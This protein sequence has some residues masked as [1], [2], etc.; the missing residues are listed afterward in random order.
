M[1]I[2]L[3]NNKLTA[4]RK[5]LIL[6][7]CIA[8]LP[9][10]L[11]L[12]IGFFHLSRFSY[13]EYILNVVKGLPYKDG[14]G[15]IR[16]DIIL[17][18]EDEIKIQYKNRFDGCKRNFEEFSKELGIDPNE[19]LKLNENKKISEDDYSRYVQLKDYFNSAKNELN[20]SEDEYRS[21]A[22]DRIENILDS[23]E[24]GDNQKN[25]EY[26]V[27]TKYG[28]IISNIN[29]KSKDEIIQETQK[30]SKYYIIASDINREL[31]ME[32]DITSNMKWA[33]D[34]FFKN[35]KVNW[36]LS[37]YKNVII[38]IS[39]PIK[40]GDEIYSKSKKNTI[41]DSISYGS[42]IL[43]VLDLCTLII[44]T[45]KL[46]KEK[47]LEFHKN[48]ASKF[49]EKSFMEVKIL[50]L[51][52][53][54]TLL[55]GL[56]D[57]TTYWG[58]S[59]LE[60]YIAHIVDNK[61]LLGIF[62]DTFYI[63]LLSLLI[64][65][66]IIGYLVLCDI[67]QLYLSRN[68]LNLKEYIYSKSISPIIYKKFENNFSNKSIT[69]KIGFMLTIFILYLASMIWSILLL[70]SRSTFLFYLLHN[71]WPY[72]LP[73]F[74]FICPL[75]INIFGTI[76]VIKYITAFFIDI[77][78]IKTTTDNIVK[79]TY[80]NKLKIKNS[81]ILK[82]LADN[83]MN[84]ED[85]LDNAIT[86][87]VKSE[88]MK[89]ELI[90]NVSHDLKTPLTSII[91]YVDLLDK[92]NVSEEKKK[93]YLGILK[94]RSERLKVLI[95]DLF[96]ASK[97]ASGNLEMHMENLDPVALLRQTLGEF[98]DRITNSNLYF[99]KN[100]PDYK[101]IIYA[102]GRRTFRV[103]QNLISNILKYSLNGTRVYIDVEDKDKFVSITFK[104][105]SK[106][107]LNFTEE[108]IL[109]RFKRGDSSRT[110]EGSGLGLA[111]AKN[112]VELQK[113]T[114]HLKFDGDLFKVIILLKKENF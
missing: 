98:E 92:D 109:E 25:I 77:N 42:L 57:I 60:R 76:L 82:E 11:G 86:N 22:I 111:I 8:L 13:E 97:A 51:G 52:L 91:N 34:D 38:R 40:S 80:N 7:L 37:D 15:N 30:N 112:L 62:S 102:D 87:A 106:Y 110:T 89:S 26:Y 4:N 94:E 12:S 31:P 108:E 20:E 100:V 79:G 1:D 99:I 78:K 36:L 66:I 53:L 64:G 105:I 114:F 75:I 107:P 96:E 35:D 49:F 50:I 3:K 69:K 23:K 47:N 104:N 113:G 84:I 18:K 2:K 54:L 71:E 93:E 27:E 21:N 17:E 48:I 95:E 72:S 103:F 73:P 55:L 68:I 58:D 32:I 67:Y 19:E 44:F 5:I 9:I 16:E 29:N 43:F 56:Y 39:N 41:Y 24:I 81:S 10:L 70:S 63:Q 46:T 74:L 88:R 59:L 90:T 85:G 61:Y 33:Y 83:I 45:K 28:Q 101:L 65:A 6:S 14:N